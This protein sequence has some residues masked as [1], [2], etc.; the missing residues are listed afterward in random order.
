MQ[1]ISLTPLNPLN[2]ALTYDSLS[3]P[4]TSSIP[5]KPYEMITLINSYYKALPIP[6]NNIRHSFSWKDYRLSVK[7]EEK[8]KRWFMNAR[9]LPNGVLF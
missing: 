7:A 4:N 6:V 3:S 1:I 8:R 2:Q 9:N 5:R